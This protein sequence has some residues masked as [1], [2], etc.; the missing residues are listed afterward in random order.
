MVPCRLKSVSYQLDTVPYQIIPV[1]Y[2]LNA[3]SYQLIRTGRRSKSRGGRLKSVSYQLDTLSY[4]TECDFLS[5][6]YGPEGGAGFE[7]LEEVD[8]VPCRLKSV[9]YQL[10]T[11]P[12]QTFSYSY[13]FLFNGIQFPIQL[14]AVCY[15]VIRTGR[16]SMSRV[17]RLKSVSY[18]LD[19]VPYQI[20]TV[21]YQ[22]MRTGRR[23]R[24]RG[25]R[26]SRGARAGTARTWSW[27]HT[28]CSSC[29]LE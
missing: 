10:D 16:R 27:P 25:G 26:R 20:F 9:S 14:N 21:S 6:E 2:R 28:S 12:C 7:E 4:S 23:S 11:V 24:S 1:S 5:A 3:V 13:S 17:G 22:V 19:T 15:E 18:Q 8:T 29:G